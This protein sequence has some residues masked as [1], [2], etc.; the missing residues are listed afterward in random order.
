MSRYFFNLRR[1]D[2][3]IEDIEGSEYDTLRAA[4]ED[5]VES[6]R[7]MVAE[8]VLKGEPIDGEALE[9]ANVQGDVL[10]SVSYSEIIKFI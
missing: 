2:T 10:A 7:E 8:L 6:V 1:N 3:L 5:A 4:Y 9:I